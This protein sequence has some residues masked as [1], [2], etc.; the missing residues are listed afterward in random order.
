VPFNRSWYTQPRL[1]LIERA[2]DSLNVYLLLLQ[3]TASPIR[4]LNS[5]PRPPFTF[6][7]FRSDFF[8]VARISL[9][10]VDFLIRIWLLHQRPNFKSF[11][12]RCCCCCWRHNDVARWRRTNRDRFATRSRWHESVQSINSFALK[13]E[14]H[15]L[16]LWLGEIRPKRWS[17]HLCRGEVDPYVEVKLTPRGGVGPE[18]KLAPKRWSWPKGKV[19]SQEVE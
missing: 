11:F 8:A 1:E 19:D 5:S 17:W 6:F 15:F 9:P 10:S 4:L 14:G 7:A 3:I 18:V 16:E 2:V 12:C 13:L